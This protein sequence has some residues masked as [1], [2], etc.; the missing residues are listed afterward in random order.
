[1]SGKHQIGGPGDRRRG[2]APLFFAVT[3]RRLKPTDK[4]A[5]V[6]ESNRQLPIAIHSAAG[7]SV[8]EAVWRACRWAMWS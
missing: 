8:T 1:L 3:L 5:T 7:A 6:A 4:R 2:N